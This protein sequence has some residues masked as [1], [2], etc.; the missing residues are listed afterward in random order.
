[1]GPHP[2]GSPAELTLDQRHGSFQATILEGDTLGDDLSAGSYDDNARHVISIDGTG[3]GVHVV[4]D[5][6]QIE[7]GYCNMV[8]YSTNPPLPA[9]DGAGIKC[10]LADLA[11]AN[12]YFERDFARNG[13]GIW[14]SGGI[15]FPPAQGAGVFPALQVKSTNFLYDTAD[16]HGGGIF[17]DIVTD[18]WVVN[19][20][21]DACGAN[22]GGGGAYLR[23]VK[24]QK[25][26]DFANAVFWQNGSHDNGGA[27]QFDDSGT[28]VDSYAKSRV[29]NCT[30]V[31][32]FISQCIA[33]QAVNVSA[34]AQCGIY[35]S[36][37]FYNWDISTGYCSSPAE[38][39]IAGAGIPTVEYSDV[40]VKLGGSYSGVGNMDVGPLFTTGN[41]PSATPFPY[42][43]GPLFKLRA[44][45]T[46]VA[47]SDCIDSA[48]YGRLPDDL[49]DLNDDGIT[50]GQKLPID[51][52]DS[53]RFVNRTG[54]GENDVGAPP[55]QGC[56]DMGAYERP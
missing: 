2:P 15:V 30:L 1:M 28:G 38:D 7:R 21:F 34:N 14:I 33:G 25:S 48:D 22:T 23:A 54:Q 27:L 10:F 45:S 51:L 52:L 20:R 24:D 37:L 5:G 16:V 50:I 55:G 44:A 17:A 4:I 42:T 39:P 19:A 32:N 35:N 3:G 31:G 18:S 12:C 53:N 9:D 13:G 11:V 43:V 56:L 29:V 6:F 46:Q 26:F 40:Y 8:N 41:P 49:A 47:G 36:I